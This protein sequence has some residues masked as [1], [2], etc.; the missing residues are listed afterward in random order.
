MLG[1]DIPWIRLAEIEVILEARTLS[2]YNQVNINS[3]I[4][5]ILDFHIF[6]SQH[7]RINKIFI[8]I[9]PIRV[10]AFDA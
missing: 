3:I 5:R 9:H 7:E 6:E 2:R 10:D 8:Q 1:L 4:I